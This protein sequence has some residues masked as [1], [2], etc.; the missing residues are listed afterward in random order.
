MLQADQLVRWDRGERVPAEAYLQLHPALAGADE[1]F[2][3]VCGEFVLRRQHGEAPRL[4]EY[5]WRFPQFAEQLH[6]LNELEG[7]LGDL[8]RI[9][10]STLVAAGT[11]SEQQAIP[12]YEV[13]GLLGRG[14]MGVVYRAVQQGLN[15][16]VA[17]KMLLADLGE[18]ERRASST[19]ARRRP[20]WSTPTSSRSTR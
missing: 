5:L 15:R 16:P 14:G 6:L 12:G 3:L 10:D 8:T 4:D 1:A 20:G 19:R 18:E 13:H 11:A 7:G 17:L 9:G 2:D